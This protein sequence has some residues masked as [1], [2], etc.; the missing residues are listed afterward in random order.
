M[1]WVETVESVLLL[2]KATD[3]DGGEGSP[4]FSYLYSYPLNSLAYCIKVGYYL[5]PFKIDANEHFN[6]QYFYNQL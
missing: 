2:F 1:Q 4:S 3:F 6:C 5:N